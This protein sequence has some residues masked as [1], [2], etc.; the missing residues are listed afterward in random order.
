MYHKQK[1]EENVKYL[2]KQTTECTWDIYK[3]T[4]WMKDFEQSILFKVFL[5]QYSYEI[6]TLY[7]Y[8]CKWLY[9]NLHICTSTK[10]DLGIIL[11]Y[12][13]LKNIIKIYVVNL[14]KLH[15]SEFND[16]KN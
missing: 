6:H 2:Q 1:L 11:T 3:L 16:L 13:F 12:N 4:H 8:C 7:L 14:G 10:K 5:N 15:S 9:M